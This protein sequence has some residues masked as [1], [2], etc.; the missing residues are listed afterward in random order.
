MQWI[1]SSMGIENMIGFFTEE[2][3]VEKLDDI[4]DEIKAER[5]IFISI[6]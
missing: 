2:L 5:E 1:Q 6:D 4:A 3:K